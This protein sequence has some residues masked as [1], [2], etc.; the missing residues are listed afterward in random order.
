MLFLTF[1]LWW[2]RYRTHPDDF[3]V[4]EISVGAISGQFTNIDETGAPGMLYNAFPHVNEHDPYSG[5]YGLGFFG[6][7]LESGGYFV[8]HKDLGPICYLCDLSTTTPNGDN[9]SSNATA[10]LISGT[11]A[12]RDAYRQRFYFEP[13]GL[14]VQADAGQIGT[15][16]YNLAVR[17]PENN[18]GLR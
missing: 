12:L 18:S 10:A 1:T 13:L 2:A 5:D 9:G 17:A 8:N 11:F 6:I 14:W 3:H 16:G 15:V 7:S 4:L